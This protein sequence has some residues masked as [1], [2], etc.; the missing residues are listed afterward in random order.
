MIFNLTAQFK[1]RVFAEP[2]TIFSMY[3]AL[4]SILQRDL[5]KYHSKYS[6]LAVGNFISN[7]FK[8]GFHLGSFVAIIEVLKRI[9]NFYA[10][11]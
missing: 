3:F 1:C 7:G 6:F 5:I 4:F 11:V 9:I 8:F 10:Y 2:H